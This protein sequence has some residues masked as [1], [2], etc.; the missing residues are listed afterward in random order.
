MKILSLAFLFSWVIGATVAFAG[1][2]PSKTCAAE[3]KFTSADEAAVDKAA[4]NM[5]NKCGSTGQIEGTAA[6]VLKKRGYHLSQCQFE[7]VKH[8]IEMKLQNRCKVGFQYAGNCKCEGCEEGQHLVAKGKCCD[9]GTLYDGSMC[10]GG[11]GSAEPAGSGSIAAAGTCSTYSG[12]YAACTLWGCG[13][14]NGQC[15]DP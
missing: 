13:W 4:Q 5:F 11:S 2:A 9:D 6:D 14:N 8:A 7:P 15:C 10:V 1:S 3:P 12:N